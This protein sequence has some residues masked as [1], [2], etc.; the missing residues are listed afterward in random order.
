MDKDSLR[1]KYSPDRSPLRELQLKMVQELLFLD[2][3]CKAYGLTYFLSGGSA[4]GAVRHHGFIPWDDDADIALPKKDY[5]KLIDI[6][7]KLDSDKY[8][9][10]DRISDFN[11]VNLFPKF[12][13]KEGNLLSSFPARGKLY[14]YRGVG[15]DIFSVEKNSFLRA[16]ICGKM[17]VLLLHYTYLIKNERIRRFVTRMQWGIFHCLVPFTWPLNVFRKKGELHYGLGQGFPNHIM[18][19]DEVFPLANLV[20]EGSSFPVPKDQDAYLTHIYGN[21]RQ[22]PS[23]EE[24]LNDIHNKE[25]IVRK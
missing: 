1:D 22:V 2:G 10:H 24:I 12:R 18:W 16:F 4:L 11:Y 6:L 25:L 19:E 17:R 3:I 7:H 9:L 13:E 23:E 14:Q 5:R 15:I 20:F 8:I 21:W